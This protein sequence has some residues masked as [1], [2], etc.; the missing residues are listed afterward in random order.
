M[1]LL[2]TEQT[3]K[4][5]RVAPAGVWALD[6]F[7][8]LEHEA[9]LFSTM[10]VL[11]I[12]SVIFIVTRYTPVVWIISEVYVTLGSQ[13]MG[14]CMAT[15]R[16]SGA[17]LLL[18]MSAA[19]GLLLMRTLALWH[20]NRKIKL[21]LLA[22]YSLVFISM[23]TCDIIAGPLFKSVCAPTSTQ[24][25]LEDATRLE[26][27]IMGKFV[28]AALF[29]FIAITITIYHPI[30]LRSNGI[31]NISKLAST[32]SKGSV[33]YALLLLAISVANIVSFSLPVS[34][35]QCGIIDVFQGVLHGVIAS[36][37]LFDLRNTTCT[38]QSE[39]HDCQFT[40]YISIPC[41]QCASQTIPMAV[42][43]DE[44]NV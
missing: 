7:L 14:T 38:S 2:H 29:E 5:L 9:R 43:P 19:E 6:Y 8:T 41:T 17:S 13:A 40:S 15:Y 4:Y 35:G 22:S 32:L 12:V 42:L 37:I 3:I 31:C 26:R 28:S 33:L 18:I 20:N 25:A 24:S 16:T 1:V 11:S 30:Q 27:L 10:G 23:A 36:R 21:L 44:I 39:E 34:Q